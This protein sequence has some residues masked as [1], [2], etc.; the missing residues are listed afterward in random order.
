MI[1]LV[2]GAKGFIGS[3]LC[4]ALTAAGHQV[5][6]FDIDTGDIS[7]P[8]AL[9]AVEKADIV[10]HLAARAFV[11][12][13][14]TLTHEYMQT[15]VIGTETVLEYCRARQA[16][17]V[18]LSTYL[19]GEPQYLPVDENHP[20]MC[21]LTLP[22]CE[23]FMRRALLFLSEIFRHGHYD[24]PAVQTFTGAGRTPASCSPKSWNRFLTRH[25]R[26]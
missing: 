26:P 14:W 8:H 10:Y 3:R 25:V 19:Y 13:S 22:P 9:D 12:D 15:N 21:S 7:Q 20:P 24:F 17:L 18:F 11:P 1:A 23:T 4:A 16:R 6:P 2:T 5:L